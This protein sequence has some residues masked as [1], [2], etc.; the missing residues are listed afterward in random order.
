[1]STKITEGW[2]W[3]MNAPKAHY[4][5]DGRALCRRWMYLGSEFDTDIAASPDDC[6]ICTAKLAKEKTSATAQK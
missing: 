1:M 2:K 3:L 6:K 5:R 4:F